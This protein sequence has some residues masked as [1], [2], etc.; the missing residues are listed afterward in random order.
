MLARNVKPDSTMV[1]Y[2][3]QMSSWHVTFY[4]R[5]LIWTATNTFFSEI[6]GIVLGHL[7]KIA[8][9]PIYVKTKYVSFA[10]VDLDLFFNIIKEIR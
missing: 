10:V 4:P 6:T 1:I 7:T 3:Y 2:K 9:T 5:P 8:P